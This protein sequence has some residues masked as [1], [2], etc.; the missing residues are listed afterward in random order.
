MD[1]TSLF[2]FPGE[3]VVPSDSGHE[4]HVVQLGKDGADW[5]SCEAY[6]YGGGKPCRHILKRRY[7]LI[8]EHLRY[9]HQ[10]SSAES[11]ARF[12]TFENVMAYFDSVDDV[13]IQYLT[14]IVFSWLGGH[15]YITPDD[16][17]EIVQDQFTHDPRIIGCTLA[18]L[19]KLGYIEITTMT[20]SRRTVCH[21]RHIGLW[22]LT[23]KGRNEIDAILGG[24]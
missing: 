6:K 10:R 7:E 12:E 22:G 18:R 4:D 23:E 13:E 5:C 20:K 24:I 21:G 8:R 16:I 1:Q 17:H 9:N 2:E 14:A 3:F 11:V 15:K 19:R